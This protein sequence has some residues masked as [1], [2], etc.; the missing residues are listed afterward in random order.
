ML[1]RHNPALDSFYWESDASDSCSDESW[2]QWFCSQRGNEFFCEVDPAYIDDPFNLTGLSSYIPHY[3]RALDI[4]L[5]CSTQSLDGFDEDV[6]A[7]IDEAA[8][9]LYGFIHARYILTNAGLAAMKQKY[10]QGEFGTC[11]CHFCENQPLLPVGLHDS[12]GKDYVKLYCPS[13]RDIYKPR[14]NRYRQIDG[15]F[16]GTSF[17]HLFVL[18]YPHF[19]PPHEIADYVPK[20]FGFRVRNPVPPKFSDIGG[21]SSPHP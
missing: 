5:D 10:E 9:L 18:Q 16:F 11:P 21:S 15:A 17:A 14:H 1:H 4:I 3:S 6:A 20:L 12:V 8:R 19:Q 2:I 13:C 7:E